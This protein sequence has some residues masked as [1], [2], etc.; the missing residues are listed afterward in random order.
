MPGYGEQ[1]PPVIRMGNEDCGLPRQ[2]TLIEYQVYP[3]AWRDHRLC[4]GVIQAKDAVGEDAGGAYFDEVPAEL[5]FEYAFFM[6]ARMPL[7]L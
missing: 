7:T 4:V 3:L 6:A 5:A 2:E 1:D